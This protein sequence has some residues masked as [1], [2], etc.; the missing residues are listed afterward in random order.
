M[1]R[2][3]AQHTSENSVLFSLFCVWLAV[4]SKLVC[5]SQ[6]YEKY[7]KLVLAGD[8]PSA[9]SEH[10][11][12][13]EHIATRP[14]YMGPGEWARPPPDLAAK[15]GFVPMKIYAQVRHTNSVKH[16]PRS[17]AI[18]TAA[19]AEEIANAPH[20]REVIS[21]KKLGEVY[22]EE[23]YE[24]S[25]YDHADF[26]KKKEH[27]EGYEHAEK[28]VPRTRNGRHRQRGDDSQYQGSDVEEVRVTGKT[29]SRPKMKL[30]GVRRE[31]HMITV[32]DKMKRVY[33]SSV[34]T[35][36]SYTVRQPRP[37]FSS[38]GLP[39][40]ILRTQSRGRGKQYFT[41]LDAAGTSPLLIQR[42]LSS[43]ETGGGE[44]NRN[45]KEA[46]FNVTVPAT[47][48]TPP[49]PSL[50]DL[51]EVNYKNNILLPFSSE[52]HNLGEISPRDN[53][54]AML[55]PELTKGTANNFEKILLPQF[56]TTN[57][58][59]L[60]L[61][62]KKNNDVKGSFLKPE[63]LNSKESKDP[64]MVSLLEQSEKGE[65][66]T[67]IHSH[68]QY[69]SGLT[70]LHFGEN[71]TTT[72]TT[73]EP[74]S[75]N[76]SLLTNVEPVEILTITSEPTTD[77][78]RLRVIRV[79]SRTSSP[80]TATHVRDKSQRVRSR[81][82]A[83]RGRVIKPRRKLGT[84]NSDTVAVASRRSRSTTVSPS[85]HRDLDVGMSEKKFLFAFEKIF[86]EPMESVKSISKDSGSLINPVL[87]ITED[88]TNTR[89]ARGASVAKL[90]N[91]KFPRENKGG[92]GKTHEESTGNRK[93]ED[94]TTDEQG[95]SKSSHAIPR[96][97]AHIEYNSE[98]YPFYSKLPSNA[99]SVNSPIRY[100]IDPRTIP[101]KTETGM[102]FYESRENVYCPEVS[103]KL[104]VIS[105]RK[106]PGEWNKSPRPKLPRL[107]GLGDKID[108]LRAKYFGSNPL[109]NPFFS[110]STNIEPKQGSENM[111]SISKFIEK[112]KSLKNGRTTDK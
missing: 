109:D 81:S 110:E 68:E 38:Q 94:I 23:G 18:R 88:V 72:E 55:H 53:E 42:D 107:S 106:S 97:A 3:S 98:K 111:E 65:N 43:S 84:K 19:T 26:E 52:L 57:V 90:G 39:V 22:T 102:E 25:A 6:E 4:F 108:C 66:D 105:K 28:K 1:L 33:P 82:A 85:F 61:G 58:Y 47:V 60:Y 2:W 30:N 77:S 21:T 31:N 5:G 86:Q 100:A 46:E 112:I 15:I 16:L 51:Y 80:K 79:K 54:I 103:P 96:I 75:G 104:D 74:E 29:P 99:I 95:Q 76:S 69:V 71:S 101:K 27:E 20:L 49:K 14:N 70:M 34:H 40:N 89:S 59:G 12:P 8:E 83:N 48:L 13:K 67:D 11:F 62:I 64:A 9:I 36:Y 50:D 91:Q 44:S 87:V 56:F 35:S 7:K 78:E 17:E 92:N 24:D 32:E 10:E 41:E 37:L 73:A 93:H 45:Y 63:H